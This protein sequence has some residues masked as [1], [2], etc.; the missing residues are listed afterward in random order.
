MKLSLVLT[1]SFVGFLEHVTVLIGI[2]IAGK[3]VG[4]VIHQPYTHREDTVGRTVWG[5]VGLG[6]HGID[7]GSGPHKRGL[8]LHVAA[9]RPQYNKHLPHITTPLNTAQCLINGGCGYKMLLVLEGKVDTYIFPSRGS[10]KWDTCAGDALL[11]AVGG[12][13]TDI[14]GKDI[15]YRY[16]GDSNH[17]IETGF[18]VT[19]D[20]ELHQTIV[21]HV[22]PHVKAALPYA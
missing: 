17:E 11:A 9:S 19:L 3:A 5:L 4:G 1:T 7:T 12:V 22:P 20:R 2:S 8:G 13:L 15:N 10:F 14:H 6:V 16:Y 21:S 18:V